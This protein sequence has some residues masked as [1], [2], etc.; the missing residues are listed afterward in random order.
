MTKGWLGADGIN[1]LFSRAGR[2]RHGAIPGNP[3][4]SPSCATLNVAEPSHP[5]LPL[6]RAHTRSAGRISTDVERSNNTP[7]AE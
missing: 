6:L 4:L 3:K 1:E 5:L 2:S 7:R